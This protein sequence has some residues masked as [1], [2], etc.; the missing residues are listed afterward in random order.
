MINIDQFFVLYI[1]KNINI[2]K[3]CSRLNE[4]FPLEIVMESHTGIKLCQ[5]S[6]RL[7]IPSLCWAP[8]VL[9]IEGRWLLQKP[10]H[11]A[12]VFHLCWSLEVISQPLNTPSE[13]QISENY[14]DLTPDCKESTT[15]LSNAYWA[16]WF[17]SSEQRDTNRCYA[18]NNI[19]W[20]F[21]DLFLRWHFE[22]Q[23][24][25]IW[26]ITGQ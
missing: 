22:L 20:Q 21:P 26:N 25:D 2:C 17:L 16:K 19:S 5:L 24:W 13:D 15:A 10:G 1:L 8:D 14:G 4:I 12:V 9:G 7:F 11:R 3:G 6:I 23:P 18:K